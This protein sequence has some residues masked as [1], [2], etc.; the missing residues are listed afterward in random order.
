MG[1]FR[2]CS[3]GRL[4]SCSD[5]PVCLSVALVFLPPKYV[6]LNCVRELT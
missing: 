5:S 3:S 6:N 2:W 4:L 1:A